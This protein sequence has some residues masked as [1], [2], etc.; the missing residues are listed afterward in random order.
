M[1]V[2]NDKKIRQ[3]GCTQKHSIEIVIIR[4][5]YYTSCKEFGLFNK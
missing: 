2:K 4:F 1:R 5:D 3:H